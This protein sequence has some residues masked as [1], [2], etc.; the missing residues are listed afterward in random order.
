MKNLAPHYG[1]S[2]VGL[3]KTCKRLRVPVPG[4]G[5]WAKKA[6]GH[7]VK[8]KPLPA[9]PQNP[10][11]TDREVTLGYHAEP[12]NL[13]QPH[14]LRKQEE[15]EFVPENLVVVADTL[16]NAH[17]LVRRTE[18]ILRQSGKSTFKQFLYNYQESYLDVE[19]TRDLLP[20]A[21]R[22]MDALVKAF[23]E[24]G[25]KVSLSSKRKE[26]DRNTYVN[27][28]GREIPFGIREKLK[29]VATQATS[30][31]E[32][33]YKDEPSGRLALVFRN[34][35][36]HGV[37]KSLDE[38]PTG[39]LEDR[40]NEFIFAAFAR[41]YNEIESAAY[42]EDAERIRALESKRLAEIARRKE[43][44]LARIRHLEEQAMQ[45]ARSQ[46]L[47][48]FVAAVREATESAANSNTKQWLTWA[49]QHALSR[50]PIPALIAKLIEANGNDDSPS[51]VA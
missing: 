14:A 30:S 44:Q 51:P 10:S 21:L 35:W 2:D 15:F 16:R 22:I 6:A 39:K 7:P 27:I 25:W 32:P 23:E 41:A 47:L 17:P 18:Q 42:W 3:A 43:E 12:I 31:W 50:N 37:D 26:R 28:L 40:L 20:R 46:T 49:E 34:S 48:S 36:G 24:R 33:K 29:K 38:T 8:Q 9:L 4:R 11:L 13:S 45:W 19:V 1:L 5:Y